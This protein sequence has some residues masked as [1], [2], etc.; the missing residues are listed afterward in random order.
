MTDML[1]RFDA[2]DRGVVRLTVARPE[3][4][5]AFDARVVDE[6]RAALAR[7]DASSRVVLLRAEGPAFS[8]G[9][10]VDWMRRTVEYG[11][12]E[13]VA[14]ARALAE[15]FR[16]ID[17][18]PM[19]VVARVQGAA[20]GGGAGLVAVADIAIASTDAVFAFS[21]VRLGII[22][23]VVSPYVVRKIGP[24]RATVL[25]VT[26]MRLD[27]QHARE[28]G[29]VDAVEPPERLDARVDETIAA[30][31]DGGPHAVN[32]AKRLVREVGDL[33]I[34][35]ARELTVRRIASLRVSDEGQEGLR[36]FLERRRPR[37]TK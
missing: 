10:D 17:E 34:A 33:P 19:P 31:I 15:L 27:A 20:I 22:P 14:D 5:N 29:L 32:A 7:V 36:A 18:L 12:S 23:A 11:E 9:A 30:I 6:L 24:A 28:I 26:G 37:W 3:R 2:D 8:A 21:E 35:E 4:R 16:A 25:F 1:V 13:N